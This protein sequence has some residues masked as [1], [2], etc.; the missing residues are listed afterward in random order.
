MFRKFFV[1]PDFFFAQD[2][3]RLSPFAYVFLFLL[4]FAFFTPGIATMPP[5]DRDESSFAQ[6]SKQMIETGNYTDIRLQKEPRYK[7]P[8]GIYWLQSAAVRLFNP[9]HLNEI[10]AYRLPSFAGATLAVLTTAAIGALLFSPATGLLAAMMLAGCVLLNVEARLAKTD[11]ALLACVTLAMYGLARAY[12]GKGKPPFFLFWTSLACGVLIKGPIILLPILAV[13]VWSKSF[14]KKIPWLRGLRPFWGC[15]YALALIAP[16]F[17]AISLQSHG[18]F[19]QQSAGHDMLAKIWQGQNRGLMPPGLY[20]L[21]LPVTFF[22]FSL[23]ALFALPDAWRFR[24]DKAVQFCLGWAIPTWLI[25]ELSLTKLPHY[26]LPVYP[27]LALITAK[28]LQDGF[29]AVRAATR[30]FPAALAIAVW[31]VVGMGYAILFAL[32]PDV[33]D[34][35]GN[36]AQIAAGAVFLVAQSA[37]LLLLPKEKL[38]SLGVLT[39]GALVFMT[40]TFGT[41]FPRLQHVWLSREIVEAA[42]PLKPCA[43]SQ[44]V[45]VGYHEPSLAFLVGT[46]TL[47]ASN[48]MEAATALQEDPCRILAIDSKHRQEF[49]D[50]FSGAALSP[51]E[52]ASVTGVNTGHG[53]RA[54]LTLYILPQEKR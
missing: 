47:M 23:F 40:V 12:L 25:F 42:A 2:G 28:F 50:V 27:A 17:V 7:K 45:S 38:A 22:P 32:L 43:R 51:K 10:W 53:A 4:C 54:T 6:A 5:T 20:L 39:I 35:V 44:L 14:D 26:V 36:N 15:L 21:A 41:M 1:F 30:R 33:T 24:R 8:I 18:A 29:P 19:M 52:V 46:E 13:V 49:L 9:D 16:W 48:G 37:A 11:A 31:V 34:H 3:T